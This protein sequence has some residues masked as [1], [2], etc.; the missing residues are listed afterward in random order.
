MPLFASEEASLFLSEDKDRILTSE[1]KTF[2]A[3]ENPEDRYY[4]IVYPESA[5]Q[6]YLQ[7]SEE[8]SPEPSPKP[9]P[10]VCIRVRVCVGEDQNGRCIGW[11][12]EIV[13]EIPMS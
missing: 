5:R 8:P 7:I 12:W 4:T 13:C 9:K 11:S 1:G 3:K 10:P 6:S 2:A